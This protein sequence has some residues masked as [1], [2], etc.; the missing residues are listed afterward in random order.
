MCR[1]TP[2]HNPSCTLAVD[3]TSGSNGLTFLLYLVLFPSDSSVRNTLAFL[4]IL[5][6]NLLAHPRDL[7]SELALNKEG[8]KS[9][10]YPK[11]K[12]SF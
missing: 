9:L 4:S 8:E 6:S 2:P 10:C 5:A 12:M 11:N 7:T 1:F 3:R